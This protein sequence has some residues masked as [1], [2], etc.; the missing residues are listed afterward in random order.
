MP[1]PHSHTALEFAARFHYDGSHDDD[2]KPQGDSTVRYRP[3][4]H[5]LLCLAL[6]LTAQAA[7]F[8]E[9]DKAPP[10]L[11]IEKRRGGLYVGIRKR[12]NAPVGARYEVRR[13]GALV[14]YAA[15]DKLDSEWPHLAFSM[16][17][18]KVGDELLPVAA[19]FPMVQLLTD[20]KN[21]REAAELKAL[22][23]DRLKIEEIGD[24]I[25][26]HSDCSVLVALIH[27]G[28]PFMMGDTVVGPFASRGGTVI[29]DALLYAQLHGI[30]ADETTFAEAPSIR[31]THE[32][33][34][35]AG[36][37]DGTLL[38]WYGKRKTTK[39]IMPKI[40]ND[41]RVRRP[42]RKPRPRRVT[43]NYVARYLPGSPEGD[44]KTQIAA[45]G[46]AENTAILD[47]DVGGHLL[48]LDLITPN[49]RAGRDPGSKNKW[50]LPARLMGSGPRYSQFVPAK[51]LLET[52][53]EYFQALY[54]K[55]NNT[56]TKKLEGG[57][58]TPDTYIHSFG[59][60]TQGKPLV[61]LLGGVEASTPDHWISTVSLLRL[62][63]ALLDNPHHDYRIPWL[64]QN[65]HIKLI[66]AL[67]RHG[68]AND[69]QQNDRKVE[70]NANFAYNWD[71]APD[72]K[73]R[74]SA[75]FSEGESALVRRLVE[76]GKAAALFTIG[77]D[78]YDAG[79]RIVRARDGSDDHKAFFQLLRD[80]ANAK[81]RHRYIVDGDKPL[82]LRL[83]RAGGL[84]TAVNWAGSKGVLAASLR[85][86]GDGEDSLTNTD[87]AVET[88]LTFLTNT[89][90]KLQPR[91]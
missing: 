24:R 13:D 10:V 19:P 28:A 91:P 26:V 58:D 5:A 78:D 55:S 36:L 48:V 16:A 7:E 81:I 1:L 76:E 66:P 45:D 2:S 14:G 89:A 88:A 11:K 44:S 90:L 47:V 68:Y 65:L 15:V 54:E 21:S 23:G 53:D 82:Q 4:A 59:F 67:N 70:V 17:D 83:T 46:S 57:G 73:V 43:H 50:I 75:P 42:K 32:G 25:V 30:V 87:V 84:P 27:G 80:V 40:S 49:G 22:C 72:K 18:G 63:E 37:P 34:L 61:L 29:C 12:G 69:T 51:P 71:A 86:C 64:L 38:P 79:Y 56:I 3:L 39:T 85:I 62:A 8:G 6:C 31:I 35:T 20:D 60:G 33:P 9:E 74:G 77:V 52:V 41:P